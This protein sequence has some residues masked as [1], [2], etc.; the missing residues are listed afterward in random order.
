MKKQVH[1]AV[2][3]VGKSVSKV[4]KGVGKAVHAS[5][6]AVTHVMTDAAG[7]IGRGVKSLGSTVLGLVEA[8]IAPFLERSTP[9][10]SPGI[11]HYLER[12]ST[13]EIPVTISC[14]D[15][16]PELHAVTQIDD[17]EAFLAMPRP[18]GAHVRW[19]NVEGLNPQTVDRLR[20]HYNFHTLAAEDVIQPLQRPKCE[21][22]EGYLFMVIRMI[23]ISGGHMRNEQVSIFCFGDTLLTI[24]EMPGD[25]FDPVRK[26]IEIKGARFFQNKADYLLY[27]LMDSV[28]DHLFPLLEG[29]GSVLE[30]MEEEIASN[31]KPAAQRRL[32]AIKRDLSQLRRTLWPIREVVDSI[33]RDES[34]CMTDPVKTFIRDVYDH[35]MQVID[36]VETYRETASSLNDLY[37]SAVGNKMNEIMKVL[38]IMASFFIPITFV[39]GVYGMNFE[40]IPELNWQYSYYVFWGV[41]LS[42]TTCLAIF[43]W[44][45][46]WIGGND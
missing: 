37:Q 33:Y 13:V 15:Y 43:F 46:G 5:T 41:C 12:Q 6:D 20:K 1:D 42:A 32:F 16:G 28:V 35:T 4:G 21:A 17:L 25:V 8:P 19:L 18:E 29:Y 34:G 9:G 40:H 7:A 3:G 14:I 24:Q 27:A 36:I 26:R 31:P 38:T 10:S 30:D 23:Q 45:K 44:R 39:A 22:Y 2:E 11:E